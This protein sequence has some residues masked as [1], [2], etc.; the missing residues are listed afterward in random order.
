[1]NR[2]CCIVDDLLPLYLEGLTAEE[3]GE[4]IQEHLKTCPACAQKQMQLREALPQRA[5]ELPMRR[6]QKLLEKRKMRLLLF[7]GLSVLLAATVI[8]A[9]LS[10]P[11]YLSGKQAMPKIMETE[12]EVYIAL[13][14]DAH[15]TACYSTVDAKTGAIEYTI[16]AWRTALDGTK[17]RD[18]LPC[19]CIPKTDAMTVWY[20]QHNGQDDI[21]L[22]GHTADIRYILPRL[23]LR[24]YAVLAG[25]LAAALALAALLCKH[26][27]ARRHLCSIFTIPAS[28]IGGTILVKGTDFTSYNLPRDM[29][30]IGMVSLVLLAILQ[31][32]LRLLRRK[33]PEGKI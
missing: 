23:A 27:D 8:F 4:M 19:I 32:I 7:T 9:W 1:M 13:S 5:P 28:F 10:A 18:G 33:R 31:L 16:E 22:Y 14:T 15:H 12:T 26:P 29:A 3:T 24:S 11:D 6:V 30:M 17:P 20:T 25:I 21:C 2:E